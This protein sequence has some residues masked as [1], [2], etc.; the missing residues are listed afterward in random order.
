MDIFL[1]LYIELLPILAF[2]PIGYFLK[3]KYNLSLSWATKL[4]INILL[5]AL[6]F[7]NILQ[8]DMTKLAII[9]PLAFILAMTMNLPALLASRTFA[10]D[11]NPHLL[12]S[13]F[14]FYNIAF[15]GVPTVTA[16]YGEESVPVLICIYIG[17]GFYGDT[18][19]Y[20]QVAKTNLSNKQA[21]IKA[22]KIPLFY[23]FV[24]ALITKISGV[25]A[26]EALQ[27][28]MSVVGWVV[29]AIGMM[30][31]GINLSGVNFKK[32]DFPYFGKLMSLRMGAGIVIM[33]VL[34][35]AEYYWIDSLEIEDQMM[36]ALVPFFP[37]AATLTIFATFLKTEQE[38]SALLLL[39]SLIVALVFIPTVAVIMEQ[40]FG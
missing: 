33:A 7:Y 9:P 29:S 39:F 37:I 8:A 38:K 14:A 12:R 21:F 13:A 24:A 2:L 40:I 19:G 23:T 27:G 4:L 3:N 35:T 36:L 25:E 34:L 26:P 28:T 11:S 1:D 20:F 16:L 31:I 22:A 5:P 30:V 32:L 15:F 17:C 6:V 18:I 10:S